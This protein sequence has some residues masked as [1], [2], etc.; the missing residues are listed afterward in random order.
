MPQGLD[1]NVR[2]RGAT[3]AHAAAPEDPAAS[4]APLADATPATSVPAASPPLV[5]DA[6]GRQ[7][8][9][10]DAGGKSARQVRRMLADLDPELAPPADR[11]RPIGDGRYE[12]KAVIDAD[13]HQGLEQL[14][15]LLSHVD[16]SHQ[17]QVFL[18]WV[19]LTNLLAVSAPALVPHFAP[20]PERG[21]EMVT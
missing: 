21:R 20:A 5:L 7:K 12:L 14:R 3:P 19:E 4:D 13:C 11:M 8:L 17:G 16:P 1:G 10:E 6:G 2:L 18:Y 15:G 9:V